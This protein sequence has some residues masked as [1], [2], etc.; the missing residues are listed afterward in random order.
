MRFSTGQDQRTCGTIAPLGLQALTRRPGD[1]AR[2]AFFADTLDPLEQGLSCGVVL[3]GQLL[4]FGALGSLADNIQVVWMRC[5]GDAFDL[6]LLG[7][8]LICLGAGLELAVLQS[9]LLGRV[10]SIIDPAYQGYG[11]LRKGPCVL[12]EFRQ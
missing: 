4:P 2:H 1:A 12:P 10:A 7:L 6:L 5:L 11:S 3:V 9:P 8:H